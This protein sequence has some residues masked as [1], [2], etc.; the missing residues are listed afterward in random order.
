MKEQLTEHSYIKTYTVKINFFKSKSSRMRHRE[1]EKFNESSRDIL[2]SK[3]KLLDDDLESE[4]V[5]FGALNIHGKYSNNE[6][7]NNDQLTVL[8]WFQPNLKSSK[9]LLVQKAFLGNYD[10]NSLETMLQ[11]ANEYSTIYSRYQFYDINTHQFVKRSD[12]IQK[13][14]Y[15]KK[16]KNII[17]FNDYKN[18]NKSPQEQQKIEKKQES[19]IT[20]ANPKLNFDDCELETPDVQKN[21]VKETYFKQTEPN[22]YKSTSI[23]IL[24]AVANWLTRT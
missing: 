21:I 2:L 15:D 9:V 20:I 24:N 1:I 19:K 10:K 7:S 3:Y 13:L 6:V 17:D 14:F 5:Y 4:N 8:S 16:N 23:N 12:L 11:N 22:K 18:H